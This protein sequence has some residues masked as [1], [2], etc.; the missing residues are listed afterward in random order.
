MDPVETIG[1][2]AVLWV[3]THI[4]ISSSLRARLIHAAGPDRYRGIYSLVA[5]ATLGPLI[6]EFAYHKHSG[7][8]LWYLRDNHAARGLTWLLMFFAFILLAAS[9]I[10]P[11]PS[12]MGGQASQSAP[13]GLQKVTRHPGLVAFSTFGIAHLLMNGWVGDVIFF[14]AFPVLG[15]AGG[16]NQDHRKLRELGESYRSFIE[17]TSFLPF[18]ALLTGKQKWQSR[19]TP[20]LAILVGLVLAAVIVAVHP[21]IFGGNPLG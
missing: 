6:Y 7:P 21:Y 9:L 2:W 11:V 18:A 16:I 10:N 17:A 4:G 20:W 1:L 14:G 12:S 19:E 5:F 3:G 13:R 15:I 8:L